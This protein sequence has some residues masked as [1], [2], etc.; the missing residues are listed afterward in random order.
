MLPFRLCQQHVHPNYLSKLIFV[1]Q[2]KTGYQAVD[3]LADKATFGKIDSV[4]Q[5]YEDKFGLS[6]VRRAQEEAIKARQR[7]M[8]LQKK[9][10]ENVKEYL[11]IQKEME[12]VVKEIM[13]TERGTDRYVQLAIQENEIIKRKNEVKPLLEMME[14]E[15]KLAFDYYNSKVSESHE[16]ERLRTENFKLYYLCWSIA[17]VG[18]GLLANFIYNR[19]K[20]KEFRD[21]VLSA[22]GSADDYKKMTTDLIKIVQDQQKEVRGFF[23]EVRGAPVDSKSLQ[24]TAHIQNSQNISDV[25]KG[26]KSNHELLIKE[27]GDVKKV[28][29]VHKAQTNADNVVYVGPEVKDLLS[30]TESNIQWTV[31][32]GSLASVTFLYG[33]LALT[34]PLIMKLFKGD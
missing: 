18:L 12:S 10:I 13:Q 26:I 30:E 11:E 7:C 15:E 19:H 9:R 8:D 23:N 1:R 27:L 20:N 24:A 17:A 4:I 25:L 33:A 21:I 2:I 6:E 29:G 31:K 28:M 32:I 34:I 5:W 22:T 16:K 14:E 3:T